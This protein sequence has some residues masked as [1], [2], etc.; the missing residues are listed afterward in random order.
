[1]PASPADRAPGPRG[2]PVRVHRALGRDAGPHVPRVATETH[3]H[4][5]RDHLRRSIM[6]RTRRLARHA[7]LG[8][9]LLAAAGCGGGSSSTTGTSQTPA[10]F[11][12]GGNNPTK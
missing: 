6:T 10:S 4:R 5:A 3:L 9:A 2:L 1:A 8:V 12:F 11:D 7:C